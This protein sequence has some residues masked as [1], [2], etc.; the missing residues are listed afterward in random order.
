MT[1]TREQNQHGEIINVGTTS[2]WA[3]V[4]SECD[5]MNHD[6]LEI[7]NYLYPWMKR[8]RIW[9]F[10]SRQCLWP[11]ENSIKSLSCLLLRKSNTRHGLV[12]SQSIILESEWDQTLP[13]RMIR[14]VGRKLKKHVENL[15]IRPILNPMSFIILVLLINQKNQTTRWLLWSRSLMRPLRSRAKL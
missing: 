13:S 3:W 15:F 10:W 12:S 1:S 9:S 6:R 4:L 11:R 2:K 5:I 8:G 7:P 14:G